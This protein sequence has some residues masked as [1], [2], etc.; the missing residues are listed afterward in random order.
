[1]KNMTRKE[2]VAFNK[3]ATEGFASKMPTIIDVAAFIV[4]LIGFYL[5]LLALGDYTKEYGGDGWEA[6]AASGISLLLF[7][8]FLFVAKC[9]TVACFAIIRREALSEISDENETNNEEQ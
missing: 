8:I 1:M 3:D 4:A 7:S 9:V 5:L 2:L 6:K